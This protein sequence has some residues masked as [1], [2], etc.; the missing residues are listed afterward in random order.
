MAQNAPNAR[1]SLVSQ[2]HRQTVWA[3]TEWLFDRSGRAIPLFHG[4]LAAGSVG[5]APVN[6]ICHLEPKKVVLGNTKIEKIRSNNGIGRPMTLN[7]VPRAYESV[8]AEIP[9]L[10][11]AVTELLTF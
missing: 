10:S 11:A 6:V 2:T 3:S 7:C 1:L 8:A 9:P 4:E 5:M